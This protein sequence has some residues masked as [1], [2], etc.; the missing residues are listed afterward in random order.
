MS[1]QLGLIILAILSATLVQE[2]LLIVITNQS[3]FEKNMRE[4]KSPPSFHFPLGRRQV[5]R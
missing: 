4:M 1:P 2:L 5:Q 3:H